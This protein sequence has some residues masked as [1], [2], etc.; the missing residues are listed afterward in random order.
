MR[1]GRAVVARAKTMADRAR[2]KEE[3]GGAASPGV[4]GTAQKAKVFS[5]QIYFIYILKA[6]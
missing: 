3:G 4:V 1:K 6:S 2:A 5:T